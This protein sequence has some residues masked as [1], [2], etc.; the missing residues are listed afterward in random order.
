MRTPDLV[1]WLVLHTSG[2]RWGVFTIPTS[3]PSTSAP[4]VRIPSTESFHT[5]TTRSS[6]NIH[7]YAFLVTCVFPE[8]RCASERT[9]LILMPRGW[10]WISVWKG[11]IWSI[12][13]DVISEDMVNAHLQLKDCKTLYRSWSMFGGS[14]EKF[15]SGSRTATPTQAAS[16]IMPSS[17]SSGI[18]HFDAAQRR[19]RYFATCD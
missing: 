9:M 12:N 2:Y 4:C 18:S 6:R 17:F 8:A 14:V 11:L 13:A 10:T 16:S 19:Y 7:M 3:I 1:E 15:P 5:K